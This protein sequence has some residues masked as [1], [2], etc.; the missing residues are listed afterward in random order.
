MRVRCNRRGGRSKIN[1]HLL[2]KSEWSIVRIRSHVSHFIFSPYRRSE[3]GLRDRIEI[4]IKVW[5]R[6][7]PECKQCV[8]R[9]CLWIHHSPSL[10][11]FHILLQP[12]VFKPRLKLRPLVCKLRLKL[13]LKFRPVANIPRRRLRLRPEAKISPPPLS[14]IV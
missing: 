8:L 10:V 1:S 5:I 4:Q 14:Y 7:G 6:T 9:A 3:F 11:S 2:T 13:R 12:E